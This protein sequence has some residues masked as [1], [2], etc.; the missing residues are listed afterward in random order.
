MPNLA[1]TKTWNY[2][3]TTTI[4]RISPFIADVVTGRVFLN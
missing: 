1:L 3:A 2:L 4:E